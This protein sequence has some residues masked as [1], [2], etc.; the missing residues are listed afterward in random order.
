[1]PQEFRVGQPHQP[2]IVKEIVALEV[3]KLQQG[4]TVSAL[5]QWQE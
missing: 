4:L 1:M 2:S 5:V 3:R